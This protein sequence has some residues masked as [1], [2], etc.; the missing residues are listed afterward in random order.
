MGDQTHVEINFFF[1]ACCTANKLSR[2]DKVKM[3]VEEDSNDQS[4]KENEKTIPNVNV[5]GN[6]NGNDNGNQNQSIAA[7][8]K[9][10]DIVIDHVGQNVQNA[11]NQQNQE[12][13]MENYVNLVEKDNEN[14]S[15]NSNNNNN[16]IIDQVLLCFV[17]LS[18]F[19]LI[20]LAK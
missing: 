13:L 17:Y 5:S 2:R 12:N 11:P 3:D 1:L 9:D 8:V 7:E 4:V 15:Q 20:F 6:D 16:E 14:L 18:S 19:V 10:Q